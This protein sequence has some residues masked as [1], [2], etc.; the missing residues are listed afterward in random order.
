[1]KSRHGV[2]DGTARVSAL[3]TARFAARVD[4]AGEARNA[5]GVSIGFRQKKVM[6]GVLTRTNNCLIVS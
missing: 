1:M 6:H 2:V 5:V 3:F 4:P